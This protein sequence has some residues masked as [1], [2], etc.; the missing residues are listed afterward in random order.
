MIIQLCSSASSS[1]SSSSSS[2]SSNSSASST[3]SSSGSSSPPTDP[4]P[5]ICPTGD[6]LQDQCP[7]LCL[8]CVTASVTSPDTSCGH[9]F[10]GACFTYRASCVQNT[11]ETYVI[12][13]IVTGMTPNPADNCTAEPCSNTCLGLVECHN[14]GQNS[15]DGISCCLHGCL[16]RP[17]LRRACACAPIATQCGDICC[18]NG[19]DQNDP[20]RCACN[21]GQTQCGTSCCDNGCDQSD[22]T[23]CAPP[24]PPPPPSCIS[25]GDDCT[26]GGTC[27]SGTTCTNGTCQPS[28]APGETRC[29]IVCCPNGCNHTNTSCALTPVEDNF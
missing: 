1:S 15:D 10:P 24:P 11:P 23:S 3:S 28:C 20:T 13:C 14:N 18:S 22:P 9:V 12:Q 27:C 21:S 26:S 25:A 4:R 2:G 6:A 19:C 5:G 17:T 16:T 7:T 8:P 29:G